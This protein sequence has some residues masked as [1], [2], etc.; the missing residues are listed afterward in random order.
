MDSPVRRPIITETVAF[1]ELD[2]YSLHQPHT[3]MN[4][5][6]IKSIYPNLHIG[7]GDTNPLSLTETQ[8]LGVQL[9]QLMLTNQN[10]SLQLMKK[11][12]NK[13]LIIKFQPSNPQSNI[14]KNKNIMFLV[15]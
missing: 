1:L 7:N 2:Q 11:G 13:P 3:Q 8:T 9:H 14:L 15:T 12:Y 4:Q 5:S 10:S 6:E